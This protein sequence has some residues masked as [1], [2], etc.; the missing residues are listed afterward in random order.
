MARVCI[1]CMSEH[2]LTNNSYIMSNKPANITPVQHTID[3]IHPDQVAA[4]FHW[5][6]KTQ[7]TAHS[8]TDEVQ[9]YK[10]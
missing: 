7:L 3:G 5:V 1:L 8:N 4:G 6:S 9:F 2:E 10:K